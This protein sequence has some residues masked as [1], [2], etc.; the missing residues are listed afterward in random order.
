M[1]EFFAKDSGIYLDKEKITLKGVS[2]FGFETEVYCLHGLWQVSLKSLLDF[3]KSNKF[4]AIR[5]P[6]SLEVIFGLD[7]LKCK[8]INT[9]VNPD[10][11]DWTPGK[12]LDTIVSECAKRGIL[13][14]PDVHRFTCNGTISELWY[15]DLHPEDKLIDAWR[16][17][18][19]RYID[20]PNV[21]AIDLKNEPHG[22]ATWGTKNIITDWDQ[23]AKRI[24]DTILDI[25]PK[26]LIF[27]EGVEK[28]RGT[29][30]WWGGNLRGVQNNPIDLKIQNKLVYSP[31]VY[32]PS[33]ANQPYFNTP[34]FPNNLPEIWDEDFG[35]IKK[36]NLGTVV[37]GEWGGWMKSENHDDV[38]QNTLGDYIHDNNIDFFYWDLNPNSTDT[39]GLLEDDWK[40]PV[41]KKL[42]LLDRVCPN[43]SQFTFATSQQSSSLPATPQ[44]PSKPITPS[45]QTDTQQKPTLPPKS[46]NINIEI[47]DASKWN[48]GTTNYYQQDVIC[49]NTTSNTIKN[50]Q[51][52]LLLSNGNLE[53]SWN[54]HCV[55]QQTTM[56][57]S[58]PQWLV[59]NG[60]LKSGETVKFGYIVKGNKPILQ[61][62]R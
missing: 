36:N 50:I 11:V 25:N 16:I 47:K 4:N 38:W 40:T 12:L 61:S 35:F 3:I 42:Q 53:Q 31:H 57:L 23:A 48:I 2:V 10:I 60:G 26:L 54:C 7:T 41:T 24:G 15:D 51:V 34:T 20:S 17:I 45:H 21:F 39:G 6:L 59:E 37:I 8:S 1:P 29:N 44:Q 30:S 18:V 9:T 19:K 14:M 5:I 52:N 56:M 32:G 55:V 13:V 28:V 49:T 58:F 33:V 62:M 43:P 22:Q 27:V 46:S